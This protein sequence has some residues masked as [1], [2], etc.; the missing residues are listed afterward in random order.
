MRLEPG[1]MSSLRQAIVWASAGQYL[2]MA[3][4]LGSFLVMARLLTPAEYGVVLLASSIISIAEAIREVAGG[5]YLV[6]EHDLSVEKVRTTMT[7]SAL[8]TIVVV[9]MILLAA[10]PLA[11]LFAMPDLSQYLSIAAFGYAIGPF[12]DPRMALFA[13]DLAFN[14]LALIN[15]VTAVVVACVSIGLASLGFSSLSLAWSGV[16]AAAATTIMCWLLSQDLSIYRPSLTQWRSVLIFGAHNSAT[17]IL[18]KINKELPVLILGRF[19]SVE[20]LAIALR[21]AMLSL[22]PE[23]LVLN[24]AGP[25]ALPE[26]SR[27]AREGQDL[28][29]AY[30]SAISFISV[31]QWP[32][33]ILIAILAEPLV[34]LLLGLNWVEVVPIVRI[35]SPAFLLTVPIGLQYPILVAA[36]AVHRLPRLL[37]LQ[38]IVLAATLLVSAPFGL[39]AVA[40]STY[41]ALTISAGLSFVMVRSAI[42]FEWQKLWL[43]AGRSAFVTL[44]TAAPAAAISWG[45]VDKPFPE[46]LAYAAVAIAGAIAGWLTGIYASG[47]P[48]RGEVERVLS[49]LRRLVSNGPAENDQ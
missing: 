12:I 21:A 18:G 4:G 17:A 42:A 16:A 30:F 40:W 26:L 33:M 13:R 3:I 45:T 24:V 5:G 20:A 36:G 37:A 10:D 25:V 8:V 23:R 11:H 44:T 43:T 46:M 2:V 39:H 49:L 41:V 14:R 7:L 31:L 38:V 48:A 19:L 9:A 1:T 34:L 27:R 6:R 47:H 15:L 35:L 28:G 32:A 29:A 22:V